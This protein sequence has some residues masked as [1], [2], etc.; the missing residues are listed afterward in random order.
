VH[1]GNPGVH[2]GNPG[3][4]YGN[5]GV[6]YGNPGVHYGNPGVYRAPVGHRG[7]YPGYTVRN[8]G[9]GY[10]YGPYWGGFAW[11]YGFYPY[12]CL[13]PNYY[14]GAWLYGTPTYGWSVTV[15]FDGVYVVAYWDPYQG[16]YWYYHQVY[17]YVLVAR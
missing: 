11:G 13:Y 10:G 8:W 16:G 17:G 4:H 1:Y 7:F 9:H 12:P 3:V 15:L 14:S 5:P 6:H 2:Y